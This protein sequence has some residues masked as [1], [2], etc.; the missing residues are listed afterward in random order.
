MCL[1]TRDYWYLRWVL[2]LQSLRDSKFLPGPFNPSPLRG[3]PLKHGSNSGVYWA[4]GYRRGRMKKDFRFYLSVLFVHYRH[5]YHP[6][7][8]IL[9]V[10]IGFFNI[11]NVVIIYLIA[12]P[13][14]K[15]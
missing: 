5:L 1:L 12:P 13:L 15:G 11:H 3:A 2:A 10:A 7:P 8:F 6:I 4:E 14:P 9:E